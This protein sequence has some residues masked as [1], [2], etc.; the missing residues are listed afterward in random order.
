MT[1]VLNLSFHYATSGVYI[2]IQYL[3]VA[4][5][6]R[7]FA[8]FMRTW[9]SLSRAE[10]QGDPTC[11]EK[12]KAFLDRTVIK[13]P[14]DL[15]PIFL[16]DWRNAKQRARAQEMA[17][18]EVGDDK[19]AAHHFC[20]MGDCRNHL[21]YPVPD[22][23]FGN[24][25]AMC[26]VTIRK[27]LLVGSHGMESAARAIGAK[28]K[29]LESNGGPLR[30][31]ERES[32]TNEWIPGAESYDTVFGRGRLWKKRAVHIDAAETI[33]LTESRDGK[34]GVEIG[35]ALHRIRMYAFSLLLEERAKSLS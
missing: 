20:F 35:L 6:G 19:E 34:G 13:D 27:D 33:G 11:I 9:A 23:Y 32:R 17:K 18:S 2:G 10:L 22:A 24:C 15:E 14:Y 5:D 16:K 4:A 29:E 30:G 12:S 26:F 3:H 25:I 7:A 31:S 21:E 28:I 1:E 8:H